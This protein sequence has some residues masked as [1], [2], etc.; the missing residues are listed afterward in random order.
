[1][2][3][4]ELSPSELNENVFKMIGDDWMLLTAVKKDGTLNTMTASWGCLGVLWNKNVAICFVRPQRYT[5]EF[6]DDTDIITFSFL[7]DGY[8]D[9]L[10]LCGT[11]SGRDTDKMK[12][13]GLNVTVDNGAA[14]FDESRLTLITKKL[15][16]GEIEEDGFA[17]SILREKNYQQGDYHKVFVC[18]IQKILKSE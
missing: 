14:I 5:L 6:I 10:K 18:E 13:A 17:E 8:R 15:Y 3:N 2:K 7:K 9:A 11:K 4:I 16:V 12:A 1:M